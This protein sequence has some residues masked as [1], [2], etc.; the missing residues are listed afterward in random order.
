MRLHQPVG[1]WL[2]LFPAW[3]AV[4]LADAALPDLS[5]FLVLALGALLM[6]SAGCVV[7]DMIDHKIDRQVARTSTRPLASGELTLKQAAILLAILLTLACALLWLTLP[8]TTRILALLAVPL[9]A[10]Y[11]WMKRITWWPQTMLGLTFNWGVLIG[12]TATGHLLSPPAITLYFACVLWTVG[13]D[14]LYALQDREDDARIGVK[15]SALRLG[16][17]RTRPFVAICYTLMLL[18]LAFTGM[19]LEMP[20]PF[21]LSLLLAAFILYG[22]VYWVDPH[23]PKSALIAFRSNVWT[24]WIILLGSLAA[25]IVRAGPD[26]LVLVL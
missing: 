9:I 21:F 8:L 12:W 3:W 25:Q 23:D 22:Q 13:Y 2:V 15:S 24:G 17:R 14:T 5:L 26:G 1:T 7:N 18:L 20:Q 11:P 19:W 16:L 10:L 6:R 4:I